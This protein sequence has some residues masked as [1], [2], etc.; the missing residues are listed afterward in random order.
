[1]LLG[2]SA[3]LSLTGASCTGSTGLFWSSPAFKALFSRF[4]FSTIL[5]NQNTK[6]FCKS[7]INK[8]YIHPNHKTDN[9]NNDC[10]HH[11]ISAV[12]PN[13]LF[14]FGAC[15]L[16]KFYDLLKNLFQDLNPSFIFNL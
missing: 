16:Y 13:N 1:M 11:H 14:C 3:E 12:G 8:C 5:F 6:N 9:E 10:C 4:S 2:I 7:K 15:L